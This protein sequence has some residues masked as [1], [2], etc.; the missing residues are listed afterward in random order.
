[1]HVMTHNGIPT[2]KRAYI[3]T[4]TSMRTYNPPQTH[5][6][7]MYKCT[8]RQEMNASSQIRACK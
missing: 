4:I 5:N 2:Y 7:Y 3:H 1:M 8:H 6:T